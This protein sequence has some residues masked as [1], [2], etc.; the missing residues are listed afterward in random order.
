[1]LIVKTAVESAWE[2]NTVL[3]GDDTDFLV[4]ASTF[5]SRTKGKL[6]KTSVEY[7]ESK[8]E[9]R[10]W[11]LSRPIISSCHFGMWHHLPH[12]HFREQ[13]KVFNSPSKVVDILVTR[14]NPLVSLYGE[15]PGDKLDSMYYQ[16]FCEKLDTKYTKYPTGYQIQ[17]QN[18][19]PIS[20]VARNDSVGV[21]LQVK[22]WKSAD[23]G[24]SL[25]DYGW[26]V[27]EGLHGTPSGDLYL[28]AAPETLLQ[29]IRCS[30][31]LGCASTRCT[32][33]LQTV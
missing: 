3:L 19:H 23:K 29:M 25:E 17:T 33:M 30:C 20:A 1:M 27:T 22:Q 18:L 15:K 4:L 5:I 13:V 21:Y 12:L 28:P 7:E 2:R 10:W 31:S 6:Q 26:N 32:C 16:R 8:R 9:V 24:M 14:E 11:C